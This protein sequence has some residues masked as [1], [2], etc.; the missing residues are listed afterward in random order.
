MICPL[1]KRSPLFRFF[2]TG[3]TVLP[4]SGNINLHTGKN[5]VSTFYFNYCFHINFLFSIQGQFLYP[6]HTLGEAMLQYWFEILDVATGREDATA[7]CIS[8]LL[9]FLLLLWL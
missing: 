9:Y 6:L 3:F 7:V 5:S 1:Y 2:I 8:Q 4:T